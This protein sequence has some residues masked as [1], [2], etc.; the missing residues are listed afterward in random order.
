M[1]GFQLKAGNIWVHGVRSEEPEAKYLG[2][3]IYGQGDR[4]QL[5]SAAF[6]CN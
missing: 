2:R 4:I 1:E 3:N 6:L 5:I